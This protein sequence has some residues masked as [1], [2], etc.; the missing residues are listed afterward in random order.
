MHKRYLIRKLIK[1]LKTKPSSSP[2]AKLESGNCPL[3]IYHNAYY[4]KLFKGPDLQ[5]PSGSITPFLCACN[6]DIQSSNPHNYHLILYKREWSLASF[7]NPCGTKT[8]EW[9]CHVTLQLNKTFEWKQFGFTLLHEVQHCVVRET[10]MQ[11]MNKQYNWTN[12]CENCFLACLLHEEIFTSIFL[13]HFALSIIRS[14][15]KN[16]PPMIG[17]VRMLGWIPSNKSFVYT[18]SFLA[19]IQY[20]IVVTIFGIHY[21]SLCTVIDKLL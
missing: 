18:S 4:F 11:K 13:I 16:S 14:R 17:L 15:A 1:N 21:L 2:F 6:P 9:W 20:I 7:C 12:L 8:K 3:H 10:R 5:V 19:L